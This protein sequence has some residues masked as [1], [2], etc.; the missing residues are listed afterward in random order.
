MLFDG[1]RLAVRR[2]PSI[3]SV[4]GAQV[5]AACW[6]VKRGTCRIAIR[7]AFWGATV[8]CQELELQHG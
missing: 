7:Q 3:F 8:S 5:I 6:Q 1:K 2:A 4:S